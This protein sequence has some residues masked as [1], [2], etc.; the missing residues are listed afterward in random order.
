MTEETKK[1]KVLL[2]EDDVFMIDLLTHELNNSGFETAIAKTGEEGI[3]MFGEFK[4][5]IILL[6]II[7]PDQNGLEVL[8]QIRRQPNGPET[9]T[10]VLS[11]VAEILDIEEAKRLGALEYL[12]KANFSLPEI[13]ARIKSVITG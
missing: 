9:K 2:I 13:T 7:L 8:R 10:I 4:P 1:T 12:V 5:D 6:D 3:K 11:N